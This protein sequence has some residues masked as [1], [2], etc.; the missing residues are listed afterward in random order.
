MAGLNIIQ[1]IKGKFNPTRPMGR[2]NFIW[3]Y[4]A[5]II[6]IAP[7]LLLTPSTE[8]SPAH[9]RTA[10]LIEVINTPLI[11]LQLRRAKA[12]NIPTFLVC[13]S[14]IMDFCI[15]ISYDSPLENVAFAYGIGLIAALLFVK[16]NIEPD[17]P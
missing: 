8:I 4:I 10:L 7:I 1:F 2:K 15:R 11:L 12:A 16:N 3:S 9:V 17:M 14:W 13:I 5:C 6:A